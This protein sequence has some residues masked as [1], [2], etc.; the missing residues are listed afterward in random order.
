MGD[1]EPEWGKISGEWTNWTDACRANNYIGAELAVFLTDYTGSI[2]PWTPLVA[3]FAVLGQLVSG[4]TPIP[5]SDQIGAVNIRM[6]TKLALTYVT[7]FGRSGEIVKVRQKFGFTFE[8]YNK[9][10]NVF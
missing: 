2:I 5:T 10:V 6:L 8:R 9:V 1:D 7:S 4:Y 3:P